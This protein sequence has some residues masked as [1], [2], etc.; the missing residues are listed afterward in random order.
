[1]KLEDEKAD[2]LLIVRCLTEAQFSG[3]SVDLT[4]AHRS[5][6]QLAWPSWLRK[7]EILCV[8]TMAMRNSCRMKKTGAKMFMLCNVFF[9]TSCLIQ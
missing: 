3:P 9:W 4:V 2:L 7:M 6:L 5:F 1:M 8:G